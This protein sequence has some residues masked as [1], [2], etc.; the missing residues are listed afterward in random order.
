[1]HS[2]EDRKD[3]WSAGQ[4]HTIIEL[5]SLGIAWKDIASRLGRTVEACCTRYR[6]IVPQEQ[7]KR[8]S[9]FIRWS[10]DDVTTLKSLIDEGR[11][12]QQI[13]SFMGKNLQSIY[14]KIQQLRQ[15]GRAIQIDLEPRPPVPLHIL[16]D[17]DRRMRAERDLTALLCGDPAPG[18][19]AWDK[20]H[21]AGA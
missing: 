4:D 2:P 17:R 9:K 6:V 20:M 8:N 7:R 12:P 10:E 15:P 11:S 14:S 1:M 13:A 21:G 18:Q 19:S 16:E 3:G 5:R